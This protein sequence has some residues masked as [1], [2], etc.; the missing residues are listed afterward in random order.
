LEYSSFLTKCPSR[1]ELSEASIYDG[2]ATSFIE[3]QGAQAL[4]EAELLAIILRTGTQ[5]ENVLLMAQRILAQYEGLH[6][7]L[8]ATYADLAKFNGLGE[9]KIAQIMAIV[10]IARRIAAHQT[11]IRA[12]IRNAK[13][14][15]PLVMDMG[16]LSQEHVRVVLLD[17][18]RRYI[19]SATVY[20]GTL[21]ASMIRVSEIFREAI[22]RNAAAIILAHN[23]P[24]G[25]SSPSPEDVQITQDLAAAGKLLDIPL[26]DHV[27]VAGSSWVSLREM[28]FSFA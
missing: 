13:D 18:G 28:G 26:L 17:N 5:S 14:V 3:A 19:A 8:S 10:E 23:H 20:V 21:N 9:S 11:P 24:S 27:I 12:L 6:G 25:D 7:L 2:T 22:T 16:T 15:A 1:T 4:S